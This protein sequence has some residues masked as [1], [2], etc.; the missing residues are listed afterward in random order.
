MPKGG[1]VAV[2]PP[3]YLTSPFETGKNVSVRPRGKRWL[4]Y[5]LLILSLLLSVPWV[6]GV[7]KVYTLSREKAR[8]VAGN[9]ALGE[10]NE[11]LKR[12]IERLKN[13]PRY[14]EGIARRELGMIGKNEVIYRFAE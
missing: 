3:F 13:D 4:K 10:E 8:I 5:L 6:Q 12:E 14:I 11:R 7:W 2:L 9:Q 1:R